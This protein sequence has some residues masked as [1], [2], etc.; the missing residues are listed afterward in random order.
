MLKKIEFD[1]IPEKHTRSNKYDMELL[2]FVKANA[3]AA[4]IIFDEQNK[5]NATLGAYRS[6]IKR[7]GIPY[8]VCVRGTRAFIVRKDG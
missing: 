1:K 4:E 8:T 7:L 3:D 2:D 6:A 5:I